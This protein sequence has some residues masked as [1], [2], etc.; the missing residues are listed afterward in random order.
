MP[1]ASGAPAGAGRAPRAVPQRL[2]GS[3]RA[4]PR[5]RSAPAAP[6]RLAPLTGAPGRA[7]A[8]PTAPSPK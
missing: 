3:R 4:W 7:G 2:T 8:L 1:E 5:D 6:L